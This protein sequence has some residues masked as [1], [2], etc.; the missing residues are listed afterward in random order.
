MRG[1]EEVER[2]IEEQA[3]ARSRVAQEDVLCQAN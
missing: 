2:F 1:A 3:V